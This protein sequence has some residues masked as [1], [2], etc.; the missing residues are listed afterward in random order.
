VLAAVLVLGGCDQLFNIQHV[1]PSNDDAAID[2]IADAPVCVA[3]STDYSVGAGPYSITIAD[4]DGMNGPDIVVPGAVADTIT[5]LLNQGDGT[6]TASQT[7]TTGMTPTHV[8]AHDMNGD[9]TL[10]LVTMVNG[11]GSVRIDSGTGDGTFTLQQS[12]ST[13]GGLAIG[14]ANLNGDDLPDIVVAKKT[15]N[16]LQVMLQSSPNNYTYGAIIAT[17]ASPQAVE[18]ANID[19]DANVDAVVVGQSSNLAQV[20]L[21][22]GIGDFSSQDQVTVGAAPDAI[23][24]G[25]VNHDGTLDIAVGSAAGQRVD[26]LLGD[27]AGKIKSTQQLPIDAEVWGLALGDINA[28]SDLDVVAAQYTGAMGIRTFLGNGAGAFGPPMD[29]AGRGAEESVSVANLDGKPPNDLVI[30]NYDRA[31]VTVTL[32]CLP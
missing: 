32:G 2:T 22:D 11:A 17:V 28:D 20:L 10:D 27:G 7:I 23:A 4:L 12:V 24:L 16:Q 13:G 6:F 26:V 30:A 9:G 31:T 18:L 21:G 29:I 8:V 25:D 5:V 14:V 15:V 3:K 19:A 1:D